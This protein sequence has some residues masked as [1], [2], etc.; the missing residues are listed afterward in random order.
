MRRGGENRQGFLD[1]VAQVERHAVEH[2]LARLDLR[3][4]ENLVDDAEQAVGG[5]LDGCQVILL[6]RRQFALLQQV[7][8]AEDAIERGADLVA[9]VG[10]KLGLDAARFQGLLAREIEF[11]VLDLD[12]FQVLLHV[13]GGLVDALLQLFLGALQ[14]FGHAVDA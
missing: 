4:V 10:E 5:L 12:G 3:E 6:A 7:G 2:Q 13:R 8:E 9:H 14:R 1:Q 11:D